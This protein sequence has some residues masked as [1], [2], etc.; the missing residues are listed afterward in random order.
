M[1]KGS[2]FASLGLSEPVLKSIA[3]QSWQQP[4]PVQLQAIPLILKGKDLLVAAQ[5][6]TGKSAAFALPLLEH[7]SGGRAASSNQ[8]RALILTPTRELALQVAESVNV[9]GK[10]LSLRSAAVYG[11]VKINPQMMKMR[12]GVDILVATPGRLLDLYQ[13]NAVKFNQLESFVLDE[14]DRM[15]DMGF[16][17][18]IQKIMDMLPRQRQN[19]LFSATFSE[20]IR[21]LAK[22]LLNKPIEISTAPPNTAVKSVKHWIA[23]VD[24]K[25][26][27]ALLLYLIQQYNW[28]QVLVFTR[29]RQAASKLARYLEG[30]GIKVAEIHGN[31]TQSAR[32]KSLARF[33]QGDVSM[34]VAT[35]LAARG[36]DIEQLPVVVNFDLPD[37]ARDYIHRIGRT[38]RAGLSGQAVSLV[39]ADEFEKLSDIEHLLKKLLVRKLIDGFEPRHDVPESKLWRKEKKLKKAKVKKNNGSRLKTQT[40]HGE[41]GAN[42]KS[43][44]RKKNSRR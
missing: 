29:T 35:D 6:G 13:H 17:S 11:G 5:T 34:L 40:R 4:S 9:Y 24:K 36:L 43:G 39:S 42:K 12:K 14:A 22:S 20:D 25:R 28:Q 19:L 7:L 37:V 30:E 3:E 33:K 16:I 41:P 18:D 2:G 27:P 15:L 10:Y 38:G 21:K 31:K 32:L 1:A 8:V 44:I 26:K 23:P